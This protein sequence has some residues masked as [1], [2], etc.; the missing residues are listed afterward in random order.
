MYLAIKLRKR[1]VYKNGARIDG[2]KMKK[3]GKKQKIFMLIVVVLLLIV[4]IFLW[5]PW[6]KETSSLYTLGEVKI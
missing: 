5:T 4:G 3:S 6:K 2:E 1:N